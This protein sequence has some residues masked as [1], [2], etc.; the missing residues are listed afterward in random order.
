MKKQNKSLYTAVRSLFPFY[1]TNAAGRFSFSWRG[2]GFHFFPKKGHSQWGLTEE[3]YDGPI[4]TLG[5]GPLLIICW[6][7]SVVEAIMDRY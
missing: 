4:F 7:Y 1:W 3:W 5:F 6:Q 2:F